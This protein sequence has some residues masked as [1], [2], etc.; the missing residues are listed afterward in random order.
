MCFNSTTGE[1]DRQITHEEFGGRVFAIAYDKDEGLFLKN[2][3]VLTFQNQVFFL[4][5]FK[6]MDVQY[7][8]IK[9]PTQTFQNKSLISNNGCTV[10]QHQ[11]PNARN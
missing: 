8:N 2:T 1:Y 11:I 9:Y 10:L 5:F 7:I 4:L 6:Q 3:A